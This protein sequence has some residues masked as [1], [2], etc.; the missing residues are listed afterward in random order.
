MGENPGWDGRQSQEA[1]YG[2]PAS[3]RKGVKLWT[4]NDMPI[5]L[6]FLTAKKGAK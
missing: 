2:Y 6:M 3:C 4:W 1:F 5:K